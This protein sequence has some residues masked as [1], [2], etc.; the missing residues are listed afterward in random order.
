MGSTKWKVI[1]TRLIENNALNLQLIPLY[2]HIN[3]IVT[4]T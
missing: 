3:I 1:K 4:E 2:R